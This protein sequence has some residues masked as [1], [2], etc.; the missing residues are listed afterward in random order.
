VLIGAVVLAA[1]RG[2]RFGDRRPK[3]RADFRGRPLV[4]WAIDA[5]IDS[6]VG[7]VAVV[8]GATPLADLVP[9]G[10]SV[11]PNPDA[12]LGLATSLAVALRWADE[13]QLDAVVVGLGDQPLVPGSAW[14]AVAS[15]TTTPI[16]VAS[17]GGRP[18]NP[19]RLAREVWSLLATTGDE[20]A[21]PLLRERPDLVTAIACEG[22]PVD[23][24]TEEDLARW[25]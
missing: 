9:P 2:E 20:G 11:L 10:V 22:D 18:R 17:Y 21:R 1:G 19:V 6:A 7:P 12:H 23:I 14:R 16:A 15:E 24:D 3:Q 8:E 25:S 13:Q 5:A 4:T